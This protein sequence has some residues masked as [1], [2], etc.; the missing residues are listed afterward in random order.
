MPVIRVL[1]FMNFGL[2]TRIIHEKNFSL[3]EDL[4]IYICGFCGQTSDLNVY[5]AFLYVK[6][7]KLCVCECVCVRVCDSSY[8]L[9]SYHTYM[10]LCCVC[11]K[12]WPNLNPNY[13][14]NTRPLS[15]CINND[16][17]L[18][19]ISVSK[20][21]IHIVNI[22]IFKR[23]VPNQLTQFPYPQSSICYISAFGAS[24]I[25]TTY[26]L[27]I[28]ILF[29]QSYS[30][31]AHKKIQ[32][33]IEHRALA[34]YFRTYRKFDQRSRASCRLSRHA[35]FVINLKNINFPWWWNMYQ[36]IT[37]L[38]PGGGEGGITKFNWA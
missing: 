27:S 13:Y 8:T 2:I 14:Y 1:S 15:I 28:Y 21:H 29:T 24:A 6:R 23:A 16:I 10:S 9:F 36:S 31:L 30:W 11:L 22:Y 4:S 19:H 17:T 38:R 7:G 25:A 26:S 34:I 32:S 18:Y 33:K 20:S 35:F 37:C 12:N 3:F 5:S